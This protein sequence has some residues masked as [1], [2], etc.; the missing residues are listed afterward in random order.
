MSLKM[1]SLCGIST[2][3][4]NSNLYMNQYLNDFQYTWSRGLYQMYR[5]KTCDSYRLS[6]L[7]FTIFVDGYNFL[8]HTDAPTCNYWD[9][10]FNLSK[11]WIFLK[12]NIKSFT[13]V[14]H[15]VHEY[16]TKQFTYCST[17]VHT[18]DTNRR[19]VQ[20]CVKLY[21]I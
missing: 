19:R 14:R 15:I 8:V 10:S 3:F 20:I 16:C 11:S 12:R 2:D 9:I 4:T 18:N 5:K 1:W 13:A 17:L 7:A 6:G 21:C